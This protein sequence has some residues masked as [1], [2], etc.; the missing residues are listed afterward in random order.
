MKNITRIA[1]AL[2]IVV[3]IYLIYDSIMA[4]VR[5]NQDKN[6][7]YDVVI[8][9]M[10]DIRD[11]QKFFRSKYRHYTGDFDSLFS[12]AQSGMIPVIKLIP[13][14]ADTTFTRSISDTI[15]HVS[16]YDSLFGKRE[17]FNLARL[18]HL[19]FGNDAKIILTA[20]MIDKGGLKVPVFEAKA[21]NFD[22]LFGLDEQMIINLNAAIE[23][24]NK[25]PG[26]RVG[27]M[28]EVSTDGNWE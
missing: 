21:S 25:F 16:V 22:V 15:G 14:P 19:A 6:A 3:L 18:N 24:A 13:D 23:A 5:F 28:T 17:K 2:V 9:K 11:I 27:N 10:K 4:P 7:R 1:L 20:G 8:Q 12:F 26:L